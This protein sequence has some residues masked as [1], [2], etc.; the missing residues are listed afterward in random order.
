[1][2]FPPEKVEIE[3]WPSILKEF[4]DEKH[5]IFELAFQKFLNSETKTLTALSIFHGFND[6]LYWTGW[7][8][9]YYVNFYQE[10]SSEEKLVLDMSWSVSVQS[11]SENELIDHYM[12]MI[13]PRPDVQL[14]QGKL[15][16]KKKK[17][18]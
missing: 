14:S 8:D 2:V 16:K 3:V 6:N 13:R 11:K 7:D 4:E 12:S 15:T 18:V 1:M 9:L 5:I 10:L 17:N